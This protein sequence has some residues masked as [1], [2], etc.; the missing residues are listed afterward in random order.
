MDEQGLLLRKHL[1]EVATLDCSTLDCS[2]DARPGIDELIASVLCTRPKRR[3]HSSLSLSIPS[4]SS[5]MSIYTISSC[6]IVFLLKSHLAC[7]CVVWAIVAVS[8]SYYTLGFFPAV[9]VIVSCFAVCVCVCVCC[10]RTLFL[11]CCCNGDCFSFLLH[12]RFLLCA[13]FVLS[14][15]RPCALHACLSFFVFPGTRVLHAC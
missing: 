3:A 14:D 10:C 15:P 7:R 12:V 6:P 4:D 1:L 13:R 2:R 11:C 8:H 9:V 5:W